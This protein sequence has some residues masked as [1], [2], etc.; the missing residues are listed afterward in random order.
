MT[1][2]NPG[3]IIC[4]RATGE[5]RP[6]RFEEWC[7]R[8]LRIGHGPTEITKWVA[9]CGATFAG[10]VLEQIDPAR[11]TIAEEV[12]RPAPKWV[13]VESGGRW[14]V[15]RNE[16]VAC[17]FCQSAYPDAEQRAR[18]ECD[19]LNERDTPKPRFYVERC[20]GSNF[21]VYSL[22]TNCSVVPSGTI[23]NN[24]TLADE[25]CA[26]FNRHAKD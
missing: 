6:P 20:N 16:L 7:A 3:D 18:A 23:L 9:S 19:R 21:A 2:I 1:N 15:E 12:M 22:D 5:A 14:L 26:V 4:F 13:V 11:V 10:Y 17:L 24:R 25:L 8:Q